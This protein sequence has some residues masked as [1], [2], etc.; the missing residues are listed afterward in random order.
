MLPHSAL[1]RTNV[2]PLCPG[3]DICWA[4]YFALGTK[5]THFALGRTIFD[6]LCPGRAKRRGV[7]RAS[8]WKRRGV[9]SVK[10]RGAEGRR[11]ATRGAHNSRGPKERETA[12]HKP[13]WPLPCVG[14]SQMLA[15]FRLLH[16]L[17]CV[18]PS[19]LT[20][21]DSFPS[22]LGS[23]IARSRKQEPCSSHV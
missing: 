1:G 22:V 20:S 13:Q 2:A 9:E 19:N 3:Q 18:L 21:F 10:S 8:L 16:F 7:T 5:V 4:A 15:D 12:P 6:P 11:H 17:N 14:L 23:R